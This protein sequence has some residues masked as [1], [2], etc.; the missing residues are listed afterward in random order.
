MALLTLTQE[1]ELKLQAISA[2]ILG[3]P[4]RFGIEVNLADPPEKIEGLDCSEMVQYLYYKVGLKVPD[5]SAMQF[6][7]SEEVKI[8]E[9]K[10]GD[11]LF[12]KKQGKV[13]H[14]ALV[15]SNTKVIEASAWDKEVI[16]QGIFSFTRFYALDPR[17]PLKSQ[18][19][20][21]RRLVAEKVVAI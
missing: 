9:A 18:Y 11:L 8:E 1:Q 5:G 12:T 10:I 19:A 16:S 6:E 3:K 13:N 2:K 20:G 21:I 14:V 15:I 7:A 4:Y 17:K